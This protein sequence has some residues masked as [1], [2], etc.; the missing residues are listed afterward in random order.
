MTSITFY[1]KFADD[2]LPHL[3]AHGAVLGRV[4]DQTMWYVL[5]H[6]D[7]S[8]RAFNGVHGFRVC[9]L[10]RSRSAIR[11]SGPHLIGAVTCQMGHNAMAINA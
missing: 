6:S 3:G 1:T 2:E 9:I 7:P 10:A 5:L 8:I 4:A 11:T